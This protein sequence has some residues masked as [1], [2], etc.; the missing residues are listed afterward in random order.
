M[1]DR[2][3]DDLRCTEKEGKLFPQPRFF[4]ARM[5]AF[6]SFHK[7]IGKHLR[8]HPGKSAG[9]YTATD[10][11]RAV[12]EWVRH[13][14]FFRNAVHE[15]LSDPRYPSKP[16]LRYRNRTKTTLRIISDL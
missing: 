8:T 10:S 5:P 1:A 12:P 6:I 11:D 16:F 2:L 3:S 9:D 15:K 14:L 7:P 4:S 13:S